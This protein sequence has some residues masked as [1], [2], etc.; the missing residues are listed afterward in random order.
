VV[1]YRPQPTT[2]NR[3]KS[4][5]RDRTS[6]PVDQTPSHS[7]STLPSM[8]N[9]NSSTPNTDHTRLPITI[10]N[11]ILSFLNLIM[12]NILSLFNYI[13]TYPIK[14][15]IMILLFITILFFHSFYLIKLANRIENRLQ[16]LH[17]LIP[18][19]SIKNSFS[20]NPKEL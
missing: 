13:R 17:H 5:S 6:S 15:T 4:R 2:S 20:S 7:N 1:N 11:I 9:I 16:S 14:I 12:Q 18:S 8:P 3:H 19:S 10:L